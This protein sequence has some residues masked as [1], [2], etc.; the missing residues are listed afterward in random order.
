MTEWAV[1]EEGAKEL[2]ADYHKKATRWDSLLLHVLGIIFSLSGTDRNEDTSRFG[3]GV[4]SS[5]TPCRI[6]ND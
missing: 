6:P 4:E 5:V 3:H 2:P 1:F